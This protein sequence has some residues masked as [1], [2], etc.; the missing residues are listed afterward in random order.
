MISSFLNHQVPT[1]VQ[2][3]SLSTGLS[4]FSVWFLSVLHLCPLYPS[5]VSSMES[6]EVTS[7]L[8]CIHRLEM[9]GSRNCD[10][11]SCL[12]VMVFIFC[13]LEMLQ[14]WVMCGF[15]SLLV[16]CMFWRGEFWGRFRNRPLLSL[17]VWISILKNFFCRNPQR[18]NL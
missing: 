16:H 2:C 13:L 10:G 4:L 15:I 12:K 9:I 5:A 7:L 6:L 17:S 14:A 11:T 3:L 8:L 1:C 18:K